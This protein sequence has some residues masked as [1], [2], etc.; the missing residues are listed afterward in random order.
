MF[1][2]DVVN[3]NKVYKPTIGADIREA[4]NELRGQVNRAF[5]LHNKATA[6]RDADISLDNLRCMVWTAHELKCISGGQ[7]G[8]YA[9]HMAEIGR[10]IGGWER[11]IRS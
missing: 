9:E 1:L 7:M 2:R 8:I 4:I 3:F 10:M 6:L 11:A 5:K